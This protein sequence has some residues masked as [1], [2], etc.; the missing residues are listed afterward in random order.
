[1]ALC[2]P[3]KVI[4]FHLD[5]STAEPSLCYQGDIASI[6]LS[7]LAYNILNLSDMHGINLLPAS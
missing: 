2:L 4:A 1:M 6:F 5:N 3:S 7:S